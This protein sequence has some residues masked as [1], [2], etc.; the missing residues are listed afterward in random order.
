MLLYD[1]VIVVFI[2]KDNI[3][4]LNTAADVRRPS[5]WPHWCGLNGGVARLTA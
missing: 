1:K 4:E 3:W 5:G 2:A